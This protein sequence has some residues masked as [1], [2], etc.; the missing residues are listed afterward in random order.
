M[1]ILHYGP[2]CSFVW[3]L[4]EVHFPVKHSRLYT[5]LCYGFTLKFAKHK[6]S[7][8]STRFARDD[9]LLE[10]LTNLSNVF[11]VHSSE[12]SVEHNSTNLKHYDDG[13]T[14]TAQLITKVGIFVPC[15]TATT[16][17]LAH[18]SYFVPSV[19]LKGKVSLSQLT[20][21]SCPAWVHVFNDAWSG[22]HFLQVIP[23]AAKRI[24]TH[25]V[26]KFAI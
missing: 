21:V 3:I 18:A 22:V 8:R 11:M 15:T 7:V 13:R 24:V 6:R 12:V 23:K 9:G 10:C 20:S 25:F 16:V 17:D 19:T 5:K 14:L 1:K 4:Q 26:N 2:G